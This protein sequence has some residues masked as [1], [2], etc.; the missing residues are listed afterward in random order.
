MYTDPSTQQIS[1]Q[2]QPGL[3]SVSGH[4]G[5]RSEIM[6]QIADKNL[7]VGIF[8]A[9]QNEDDDSNIKSHMRTLSSGELGMLYLYS[10]ILINIRYDSLI[11]FD[12]LENHLHPNSIVQM[13]T[14]L[15]EVLEEF[16]SYAILAT[17]SPI[18]IQAVRGENVLI[19]TR[20]ED[21][22]SVR[23]IDRESLG[24][25]LSDLT[26]NVFGNIGLPRYYKTLIDELLSFRNP[27]EV[28]NLLKND[29][30]N[31]SLSLPMQL[32][33]D[34]KKLELKNKQRR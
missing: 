22:C 1:V 4:P 17:H 14:L 11:L 32:Y 34:A 20:N 24:A 19:M 21:Y 2:S 29:Q 12:E 8:N 23:K 33:I 13:V 7:V 25:N 28:E 10:S 15:Y 26:D 30:N 27:D 9:I 5:L 18:V 31:R 16:E 3:H 6:S